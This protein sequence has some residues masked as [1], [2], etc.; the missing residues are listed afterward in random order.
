MTTHLQE[1]FERAAALIAGADLLVIAA[2]AGMGVDSGLPDFRANDGFWRAYPALQQAQLAFTSI[3]SPATFRERPT[4]A[5]GFYGHRLALYRNTTPHAGFVVLKRWGDGMQ[6]G[7][8]VFTSNVDGQ[9]QKAAFN[10]ASIEQC[11]G[12]IHYMQCMAPCREAIWRADGFL[13]QV[14]EARCMLVGALPACPH[15]G[16]RARPN[17]LMFGDGQWLPERSEAQKRRLQTRLARARRPVVLEIG[18]GSAIPS[19]RHFSHSVLKQHN[20]RL[21]RINP[22]EATVPFAEDVALPCRALEALMGIDAIIDRAAV[23]AR[24]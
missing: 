3:A 13:P 9:F 10:D 15:C 8:V 11:H 7:C 21:V 1:E 16:A 14:D 20:G 4:L 17:M 6:H 18:A 5:W 2:G 23:A 19:V 22:T 12:S 24:R